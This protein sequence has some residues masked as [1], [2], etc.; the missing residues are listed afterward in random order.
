MNKI[1]SNQLLYPLSGSFTG[2]LEGTAS[3]ALNSL[4]KGGTDGFLPIWNSN[5]TLTTSSFYQSSSFTGL[6]LTSPI[7]PTNPDVLVVSAVGLDTYNILSAHGDRNDFVQLNVQNFNSSTHASSDIVATA[8]NG[9]P[10]N[11]YVS[12][13]I[14]SSGYTNTG[15]VGGA[16]DA[17]V[18]STG[19]DLY[20]GNASAGREVIIFNGGPDAVNKAKL[21]I[22]DQG[23]IGINTSTYNAINPPSL[24]IQ[25]IND[26]IF[27]VVQIY[28]EANN[29]SQVANTNRSGN[30]K[31][32]ADYI[33]YNNIDPDNQ[34][35][36][37]IDM[38]I[39][40]TGYNDSASYPGWSGG[41]S[42]TYTDAPRMLIGST[43]NTSSINL[44]VGGVDPNVNA[45]L[46]LRANNQHSVTGSLYI[47][48]S[49]ITYE[50][51]IK[52]PITQQAIVTVNQNIVNI[53][54]H[55]INPSGTTTA[56]SI[57]FTSSSMYIGLE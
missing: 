39:T 30:T 26:T 35:A 1:H 25:A 7:D 20:I 50:L 29:Y 47:T 21:F 44:F 22:H 52:N 9:D 40:S 31:A 49:I 23:T 13:G 43:L 3:Y 5:N 18:Y 41:D 2:S 12:M 16:N 37:F 14:N 27:N 53:A 46:I 15:N 57:Y 4:I 32:S 38:G 11:V 48:G 36:G 51:I 8:D 28:N 34:G 56:G 24:Q 17:Y 54:T 45:K 19:N 33:A 42:Y 55:S 10:D 6:R